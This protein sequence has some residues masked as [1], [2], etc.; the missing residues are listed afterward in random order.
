[1]KINLKFNIE[2]Y[3]RD[4]FTENPKDFPYMD[5]FI[6][7]QKNLLTNYEPLD[8]KFFVLQDTSGEYL[9]VTPIYDIYGQRIEASDIDNYVF[10]KIQDGWI[11]HRNAKYLDS[12]KD[13]FS[14][15]YLDN[16]KNGFKY[17]EDR[18][19]YVRVSK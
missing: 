4:D 1:M 14:Y 12:E 11:Y 18:K 7:G 6:Y 10:S 8:G 3:N 16:P 13:Y 19:S 9:E 17:D 2:E 15:D 5:T